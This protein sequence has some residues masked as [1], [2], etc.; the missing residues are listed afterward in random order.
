MTQRMSSSEACSLVIMFGIAMF[1]IVRS[2]KVMKNPR[3]TTSKTAH[4]LARNFVTYCSSIC[5]W[6]PHP[7]PL[8]G[9]VPAILIVDGGTD[10]SS[11][12]L[13]GWSI[14]TLFG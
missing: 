1:T 4:G 6:P 14:R 3:D 11:G 7:R 8:R 13:T 12:R 10:T 2:S 5:R 9:R